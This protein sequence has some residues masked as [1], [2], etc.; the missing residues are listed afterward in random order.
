MV[1]YTLL[2]GSLRKGGYSDYS[3]LLLSKI[4]EFVQ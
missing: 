3:A 2:I 1:L 4:S